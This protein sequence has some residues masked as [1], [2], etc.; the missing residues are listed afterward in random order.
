M[1]KLLKIVKDPRYKNMVLLASIAMIVLG[2]I[3]FSL[4]TWILEKVS[5]DAGAGLSALV[6]I[7]SILTFIGGAL[8]FAVWGFLSLM[9][10]NKTVITSTNTTPL[11]HERRVEILQRE[12]YKYIN[13]GYRVVSQTDT[14]AQLVRPKQFSCLWFL[15]NALLVIGWVFYLLWYWSKRDEQIYIEVDLMGNIKISR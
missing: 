5:G 15:I 9:Q 2:S 11:P 12:V 8:L 6:A 13:Q 1:E 14:T 10:R 7:L 3:G 4:S